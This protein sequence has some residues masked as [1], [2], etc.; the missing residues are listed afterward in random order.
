MPIQDKFGQLVYPSAGLSK[1]EYFAVEIFKS[2]QKDYGLMEN[3]YDRIDSSIEIAEY[4]IKKL[5]DRQNKIFSE[6]TDKAMV[7]V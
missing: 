3:E 7:I 2:N 4:F 1:L 5:S 6:S